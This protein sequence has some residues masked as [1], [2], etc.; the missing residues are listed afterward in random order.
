MAHFVRNCPICDAARIAL[1]VLAVSP[2]ETA[3]Q[4]YPDR[5]RKETIVRFIWSM[6]CPDCKSP[7]G[8]EF[9][10]GCT[11]DFKYIQKRIGENLP[12]EDIKLNICKF[13]SWIPEPRKP[14]IP[15]DLP[16]DVGCAFFQAEDNFRRQNNDAA[17]TMYRKALELALNTVAPQSAQGGTLFVR[18]EALIK[19]GDVHPVFG[20][21]LH[22]VRLLG[23][24]AAHGNGEISRA[25]LEEMRGFSEMILMYLFTLPAKIKRRHAKG[26]NTG[27]P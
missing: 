21:W 20:E 12:I 19:K 18:I 24:E 2:R 27:S 6:Q 15:D 7:V 9:D 25:D 17:G 16:E 14:Q 23:N 10:V 26:L 13:R 5:N 11:E 8:A 1:K 3:F 22:E 4:N